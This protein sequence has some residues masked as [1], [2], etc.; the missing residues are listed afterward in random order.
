[1]QPSSLVTYHSRFCN[2]GQA[3]EKACGLDLL[4]LKSQIAGPA[5][6]MT[7]DEEDIV[8]EAIKFFRAQVMFKNFEVKGD[9]DKSLIF[10]TVFIQKCL[11]TIAKNQDPETV[12]K[13]LT[14]L[15]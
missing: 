6:K 5:P 3:Y 1:M 4:P 11:E 14:T 8:D 9:A 12:K 10:L 7:T 13:N 2:D 15:A